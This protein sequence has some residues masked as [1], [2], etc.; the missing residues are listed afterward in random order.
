[1]RIR[2]GSYGVGSFEK[3]TDIFFRLAEEVQS[4]K[5]TYKPTFTQIGHIESG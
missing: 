5:T 2:F 4:A 1:M 3:G